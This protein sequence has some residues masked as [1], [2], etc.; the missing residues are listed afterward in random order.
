VILYNPHIDDFLGEPPHFRILHR[1]ALKKYGFLIK[2]MMETKQPLRI[3]LDAE[4]SAFIPNPIFQRLPSLIRKAICR[5]EFK[6]WCRLNNL[7][8]SQY[9]LIFPEELRRDD[10]VFAFSYKAACGDFKR[11]LLY[12]KRCHAVVFHLSHYFVATREKSENMRLLPNVFLAG[13]SN[14]SENSYFKEYF[15]WYQ[16]PFLVLPFAVAPRFTARVPFAARDARCLAT[17]SFHDLTLEKPARKYVD[18]ISSSGLS[19]YH[20][21]RKGIFDDQQ[22]LTG[23]IVSHI[24]PYRRYH[25]GNIIRRI[26][27]HLNVSQKSYF[28]QDI[29]SL[30][31][32]YRYAV[33]GEEWS[34][35][36]ALG[37][38]EAMAC[39]ALLIG[40]P[41]FYK[42]L[43][44]QSN[45]HFLPHDGS[46]SSLLAALDNLDFE[47][48]YSLSKSGHQFVLKNFN[49]SSCYK[50]WLKALQTVS[51]DDLLVEAE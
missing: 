34:G 27:S 1:R 21:L 42:G 2:G 16:R 48:A 37:A 28:A 22:N 10:I 33:V 29:V 47:T 11:R 26:I 36:P 45:V 12:F 31:N 24:S 18:Y 4:L 30:Y 9:R 5:F 32:H 19:T 23:L 46:L 13:D 50:R 20:P 51:V 35:F 44:I 41:T 38:L 8:Q 7:T 14:I 49:P 6:I 43:D 17:G 25:N 3:L 15:S 40:N 39:G